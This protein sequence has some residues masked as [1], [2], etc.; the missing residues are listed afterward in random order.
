M[1]EIGTVPGFDQVRAGLIRGLADTLSPDEALVAQENAS[2]ALDAYIAALDTDD[3]DP[4]LLLARHPAWVAIASLELDRWKETP[5]PA[6]IDRA[7][8]LA[9]AGFAAVGDGQKTGRGEVLWAIAEQADDAG[10]ATSATEIYESAVGVPF[11][12][13][14][15]KSQ[16]RLL[17]GLRWVED[18]DARGR[19]LLAEVA[20][21]ALATQRSRV[22]AGWVLAAL[23]SEDGDSEAALALLKA[24]RSEVDHE[25]EPD[26]AHRLDEAIARLIPSGVEAQTGE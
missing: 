21:D 4:L 9:T 18:R 17:L 13:E 3:L 14:E 8:A 2:A 19:Q 10:W 24:A 20:E 7:V 22:H 16:V 5:A 6:S 23:H 15:G 1:E 11:A 26:V 25:D 12:S